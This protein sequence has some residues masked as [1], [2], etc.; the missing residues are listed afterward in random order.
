MEVSF[1]GSSDGVCMHASVNQVITGSGNGLLP[2]RR[3]T[4]IWP[5]A[6]F[7][8]NQTTRDKPQWNLNQNTYIYLWK[9]E[10]YF[11]MLCEKYLSFSLDI[12]LKKQQ[13]HNFEMS[14]AKCLPFSLGLN[15]LLKD[16]LWTN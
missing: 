13:M 15:V 10:M 11:K 16:I 2:V 7:I 12:F 9:K 6:D 14:L 8:I 4:I 1:L 5:N 3:Q